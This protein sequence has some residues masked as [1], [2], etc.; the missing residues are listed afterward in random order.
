MMQ[1]IADSLPATIIAL[2][3]GAV[4][5]Q[6]AP[7]S[8]SIEHVLAY[9]LSVYWLISILVGSLTVV[10]GVWFRPSPRET[11]LGEVPR[12]AVVGQGLEFAGNAVAGGMLTVYAVVLLAAGGMTSF[13]AVCF[14]LALS[15]AYLGPWLVIIRDLYRARQGSI[16]R[17]N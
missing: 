6:L 1:R 9:P 8:E 10:V 13:L 2:A 4:L 3:S 17:G 14:M 12:R 7:G 16:V 11:R 15:S 5:A